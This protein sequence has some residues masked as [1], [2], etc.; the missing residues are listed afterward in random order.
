VAALAHAEAEAAAEQIVCRIVAH[1]RLRQAV[2]RALAREAAELVREGWHLLH[3]TT[4]P[5]M[6]SGTA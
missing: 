1:A 4:A 2:T 3:P 6:R 5:A